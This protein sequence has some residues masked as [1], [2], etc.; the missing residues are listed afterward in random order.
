MSVLGVDYADTMTV[1]AMEL[2]RETGV[3]YP[4]VADPDSLVNEAGGEVRFLGLPHFA[5][6]DADGHVVHQRQGGIESSDDLVALVEEHFGL[7]LG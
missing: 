5:L 3:T 6:I 4:L 1:A 7:K 2:V